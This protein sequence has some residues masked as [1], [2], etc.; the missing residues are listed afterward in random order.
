MRTVLLA[1]LIS[2]GVWV[3]TSIFDL[4]AEYKEVTIMAD[5]IRIIKTCLIDGECR[6]EK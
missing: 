1:S 5:D 2:M 4:K 6:K 3:V